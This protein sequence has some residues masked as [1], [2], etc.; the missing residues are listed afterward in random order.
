MLWTIERMERSRPPGVLSSTT[1]AWERSARARSMALLRSRTVM[2]LMA[3]SISMIETGS[4]ATAGSAERPSRN[5]KRRVV[6]PA[7]RHRRFIAV[8]RP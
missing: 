1:S 8:S 7:S 2:G 3:P 4:T 6:G 5:T